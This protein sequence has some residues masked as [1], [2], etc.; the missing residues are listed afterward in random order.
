M[1]TRNPN[2]ATKPTLKPVNFILKN[3]EKKKMNRKNVLTPSPFLWLFVQPQL[4]T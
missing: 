2:K 1:E 4:S 3:S